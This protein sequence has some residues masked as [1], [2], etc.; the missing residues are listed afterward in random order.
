MITIR[1]GLTYHYFLDAE[2]SLIL[3]IRCVE[4]AES[5]G[6][7]GGVLL[8]PFC[9]GTP[10]ELAWEGVEFFDGKVRSRLAPPPP[11]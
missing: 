5:L 3:P 11:C 4:Y 1:S 10:P 7:N 2:T 8:Y 9:G 6:E